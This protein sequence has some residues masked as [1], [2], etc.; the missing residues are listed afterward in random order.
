MPNLHTQAGK[1]TTALI[2]AGGL[3][4]G[5]NRAAEGGKELA[6]VMYENPEASLGNALMNLVG[7]V[8]LGAVGGAMVGGPVGAVIGGLAGM[9][10][11]IVGLLSE[12]QKYIRETV[13]ADN[14]ANKA[15][16]FLV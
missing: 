7:G 5:L 2:G 14:F 12:E 13:L 8:G 6:G 16:Q 3:L 15:L 10:T 9:A 1:V 4:Y 11:G